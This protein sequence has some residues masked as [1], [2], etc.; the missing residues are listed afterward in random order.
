MAL[1]APGTTGWWHCRS[2][3][4][5]LERAE[6]VVEVPSEVEVE[7]EVEVQAELVYRE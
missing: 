3:Q 7:V 4:I 6:V 1:L 5:E 2:V